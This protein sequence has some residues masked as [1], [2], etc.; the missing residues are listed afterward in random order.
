MIRA[1]LDAL[2]AD[3]YAPMAVSL[4]YDPII[5]VLLIAG[6]L[7]TA[8]A[9]LVAGVAA[10]VY[11]ERGHVNPLNPAVRAI[12]GLL[13]IALAS[14]SL[15]QVVLIFAGIYRLAAVLGASLAALAA[16]TV[17]VTHSHLARRE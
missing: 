16:V 6:N 11:R 9:L 3:R 17:V 5:M 14:M 8:A 15:L 10:I 1:F 2:G 13:S 7:V 4:T 12:Y